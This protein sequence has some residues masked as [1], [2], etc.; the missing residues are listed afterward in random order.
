M[1]RIALFTSEFPPFHGGIG[2]YARELAS[3]AAAAGHTVTVLA[4]DYSCDCTG[5]DA[6]FAFRV[7]RYASGP[8]TMRTLP[9]RVAA[10]RRLLASEQFDIVHAADWPFYI[11]VRL[12]V[13]RLDGARTLLTA[14]GSEVVYMNASRRRWMLAAIGFWRRGWAT[15]IANSRYT[16]DLLCQAFPQVPAGHVRAIPLALAE[17]WRTAGTERGVARATLGVGTDRFV[18]VSLGRVVPRKGH[19]VIAE[20]LALLPCEV[21]ARIDWWVIGPLL[22]SRHADTLKAATAELPG[23]TEWLG[24]VPDVE[25]RLRLSA[26]DLFCLPGYQDKEGKVEGFGLV[27]LE[28][29]ALGL[30]SVATRSGGIPEAVEDGVTGLLVPERDPQAVATSIE[31]LVREPELRVR[32]AAGAKARADAS[33]WSDVMR[34]TYEV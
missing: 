9:H 33:C 5:I 25:V 2:A 18:I 23:R 10:A 26:G 11:P 3:A 20:A 32:L 13:G 19:G 30:P 15:W 34:R 28:A 1:A 8:A 29:G 7:V 14:H 21:S 27:F 31:R 6:D 12:A 17:S 24:A 16:A 4:P 22:D